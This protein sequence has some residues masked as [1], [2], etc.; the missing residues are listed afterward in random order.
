MNKIP[1]HLRYSKDHEWVSLDLETKVTI[2]G[3][4]WF[5]QDQLGDIVFV[6]FPSIGQQIKS[7]NDSIG[8]IEAVKTVSDIFSPLLG[9]IIEINE[10]LIKNPELINSDP[11]KNWIFKFKCSNPENYL[12]DTLS[13]IEYNSLIN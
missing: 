10:D 12:T 13:N 4:T 11:Y 7:I 5:A 2:L 3:I 8:A 1:E 9:E 6:E